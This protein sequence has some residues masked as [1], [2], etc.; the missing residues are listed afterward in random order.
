[1]DV[2][3]DFDA[4]L[5][6]SI[7]KY[8]IIHLS[9]LCIKTQPWKAEIILGEAS[10]LIPYLLRAEGWMVSHP[11]PLRPL[12]KSLETS[13]F[14]QCHHPPYGCNHSL[15][16]GSILKNL[17]LCSIKHL[18]IKLKVT[19]AFKVFSSCPLC[20]DRQ[21]RLNRSKPLPVQSA[22]FIVFLPSKG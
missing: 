10:G 12:T 5:L 21:M 16:A 18:Y 22:N 11:S 2:Y 17:V 19:E 14:F 20:H 13:F 3:G 15:R 6:V 4:C 1:M 7:I 9:W 8:Y